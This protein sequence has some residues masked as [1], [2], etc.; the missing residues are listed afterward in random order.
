MG[1]HRFPDANR[2]GLV[3]ALQQAGR[4]EDANKIIDELLE[5][6]TEKAGLSN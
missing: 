1:G 2:Y 5:V 6:A 3:L 4:F